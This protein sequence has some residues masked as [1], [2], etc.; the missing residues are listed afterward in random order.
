MPPTMP[1]IAPLDNPEF[2]A[3]SGAPLDNREFVARSGAELEGTDDGV[4]VEV[5][6]NVDG[7]VGIVEIVGPGVAVKTTSG[8]LKLA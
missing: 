8:I 5:G 4:V 3:R 7:V 1:P 2:E 6:L